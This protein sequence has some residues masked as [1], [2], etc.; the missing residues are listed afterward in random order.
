M[1]AGGLLMS[2]RLVTAL[3]LLLACSFL[4]VSVRKADAI[5]A[6]TRQYKTECS[7]CHT[8]YPEL[9]E[10][11]QAFQKN[12]FVYS[13]KQKAV[14]KAGK[15][16]P[17]G[18]GDKMEGLLLSGI[19]E[20][21]P[22]SVT[23]NQSIM[24][25]DRSPNGDDWDFTTRS[26]VLQAGGAFHELAGF[27]ATYD[28]YSHAAVAPQNDSN[29]LDELFL[30]WRHAFTTPVNIKF[31]KFEPRLSLWKKSEK[32]I[33]TSFATSAYKVGSSPFSMET[34]QDALEANAIVGNRVFLAA[35]AV[36]RKG[37]KSVDGYGH[38]SVKFGG[39]DF[40]GNEPEMDFDSESIWDYLS[41]T[42]A[43]YGYA[44]RNQDPLITSVKN[45]FYRV[46]G[47]VD[48][49][50]KRLRI[51]FSAL[52]GRDTNPDFQATGKV[53]KSRVYASE[54]EYLFGSPFS[55]AGIFRYEYQDDGS[56]IVRRYIPALA[57]IPLQNVKLVLQYNYETTPTVDNKIAL[58]DVAFSF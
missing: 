46:G 1:I 52:T 8:I 29:K 26:V 51:R 10:Y 15:A 48:L 7:T 45:N 32:I 11:G 12:G 17:P 28:L 13:E 25:N 22:L 47:D 58:L 49:L 30:V 41:L 53:L 38:V 3:S 16:G 50:Y 54:A 57:Y 56:I 18:P 24:Y 44:G 33:V 42:L 40:H 14:K 39:T 31:G 34:T 37:Q 2:H 21:L 9:N 55:V 23:A 35:G 36:D 43:G 4:L 20:L 5:P 27:F 6:F 19:P